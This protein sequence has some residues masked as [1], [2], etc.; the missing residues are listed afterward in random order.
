MGFPPSKVLLLEWWEL[1]VLCDAID[2]DRARKNLET[3]TAIGMAFGNFEKED[4]RKQIELW[5][6]CL[7]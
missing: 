6:D 1:V 7:E 3:Y 2:R 5:R 4:A